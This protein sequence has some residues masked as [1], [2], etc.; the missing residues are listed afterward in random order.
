MLLLQSYWVKRENVCIL[1]RF[2]E[3]PFG[4]WQGNSSRNWRDEF[5]GGSIGPKSPQSPFSLSDGNLEVKLLQRS[6]S[7]VSS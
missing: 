5:F 1:R 4:H 3:G 7:F 6:F 2:E